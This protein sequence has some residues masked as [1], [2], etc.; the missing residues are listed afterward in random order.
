[1]L[2]FDVLLAFTVLLLVQ[3]HPRRCLEHETRVLTTTASTDISQVL[4]F[5]YS[6]HGLGRWQGPL[7]GD[8]DPCHSDS[9]AGMSW[10]KGIRG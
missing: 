2:S 4:P 10:F 3:I 1:M 6:S 5:S 7:G 8:G 9:A